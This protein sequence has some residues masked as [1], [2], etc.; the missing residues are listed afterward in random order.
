MIILIGLAALDY[1]GVFRFPI[2]IRFAVLSID[3]WLEPMLTVYRLIGL[4]VTSMVLYAVTGWLY[5]R[6]EFLS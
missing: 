3:N 1:T 6:K 2:F 4:F 5:E